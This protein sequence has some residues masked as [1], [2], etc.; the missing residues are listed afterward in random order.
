MNAFPRLVST[1]PLRPV[2]LIR[3]LV[4]AVFLSEGIQK[5][6]YPDEVGAGRF[7]KIGIPSPEIL[8][9]LVGGIEILCGGLILLGLLTRLAAIPLLVTMSVAV[10]STKIP[11]LLNQGFWKMAH[12]SRTDYSMI[13]GLVFLLVVGGGEWSV[14]RKLQRS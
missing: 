9:P 10:I 14:D 12:D 7:L 13:L 3:L 2:I 1:P 5:F 4:G 8:G 11:I 6:L